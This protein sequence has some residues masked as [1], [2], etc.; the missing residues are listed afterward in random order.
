MRQLIMDKNDD[1]LKTQNVILNTILTKSIE[2][3]IGYIAVWLFKPLWNKIVK[4]W[5]K[6]EPDSKTD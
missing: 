5:N 6:N 1:S 2:A 4:M 3:I